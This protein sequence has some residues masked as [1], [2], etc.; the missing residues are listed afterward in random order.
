MYIIVLCNTKLNSKNFKYLHL[1]VKTTV[2]SFCSKFEAQYG[3][4]L[5][6]KTNYVIYIKSSI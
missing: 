4:K 3:D 2:I 1:K 5:F 6:L